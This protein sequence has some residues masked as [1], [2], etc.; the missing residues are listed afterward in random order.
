M[1]LIPIELLRREVKKVLTKMQFMKKRSNSTENRL[2]TPLKLLK[3]DTARL[4]RMSEILRERNTQNLR[5]RR[6]IANVNKAIKLN[7]NDADA[8]R[9]RGDAYRRTGEYDSTI[10]YR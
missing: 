7:P 2:D 10:A 3:H 8:Y 1:L 9:L 4:K 5:A 6:P